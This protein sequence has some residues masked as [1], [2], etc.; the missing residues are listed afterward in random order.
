MA[1]EIYNDETQFIIPL[2]TMN[3]GLTIAQIKGKPNGIYKD[4]QRS[5]FLRK[6]GN[7]TNGVIADIDITPL[8]RYG[9][10]EQARIAPTLENV[11]IKLYYRE[12]DTHK[13]P[14]NDNTNDETHPYADTYVWR[15]LPSGFHLYNNDKLYGFEWVVLQNE[16]AGTDG[17]YN[18]HMNI[19]DGLG[20]CKVAASRGPVSLEGVE[21]KIIITAKNLWTREY[22]L[23]DRDQLADTLENRSDL[24][25]PTVNAV[26]DYYKNK[27]E[28]NELNVANGELVSD[29]NG[30]KIKNLEIEHLTLHRVESPDDPIAYKRE[31]EEHEKTYVDNP[32]K[33]EHNEVTGVHGIKN[34]GFDGNIQASSLDGAKLSNGYKA[35]EQNVPEGSFIPFVYNGPETSNVG[36]MGIGKGIRYFAQGETTPI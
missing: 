33:D 18:L 7:F 27:V 4:I 1:N 29:E 14:T 17:I 30:T 19:E 25:A 13:I 24:M 36:M 16:Y 28:T 31:L 2:V 9:S 22:D 6:S 21:Y 8:V 10:L 5:P 35:I 23:T 12:P 26:L 15:E 32:A 20:V 11:D 34:T 3:D